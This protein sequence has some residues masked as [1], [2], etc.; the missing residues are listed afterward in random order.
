MSLAAEADRLLVGRVRAGDEGAWQELINRYEGRL[1][2]F[3]SSRLGNRQAAEDAVQEAFLGFIVSLPNYD[4]RT[5][6]ESYLFSITAHKLTDSLRRSG[7]RPTLPLFVSEEGGPTAEPM[8]RARHASSLMRSSEGKQI[9]R[10]VIAECLSELIG[11]WK[12]RG[13]WER[14]KCIELL[15]VAGVPNKEVATTL[16]LTQQDVANHKQF[17]VQKLKDAAKR[18]RLREFDVSEYGVV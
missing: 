4:E 6:L 9:E 10:R 18:A 8:G 15:F 14:L 12:A 17:V 16:G 11:E 7:R 5:P 1:L 2:A 3:A 13:D